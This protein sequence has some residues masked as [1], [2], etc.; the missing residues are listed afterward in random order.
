MKYKE[1]C[2]DFFA[3]SLF[4]LCVVLSFFASTQS[5]SQIGINTTAPDPSSM[6]DVVATDKGMLV[7]RVSLNNVANTMLD[8]TNT[9]ATGLLI[10]NTNA[11]VTGGSGVGFYYF[12]GS[13]W[14]RLATGTSA[15]DDHDFYEEGTTTPPNDINDDMFT[16]GNVAIG[17]TTADYALDIVED[18]ETR[19]INSLINSTASG[20]VLSYYNENN[21]TNASSTFGVYNRLIANS[22]GT[23]YGTYN[24]VLF[25]SGTQYGIFNNIGGTGTSTRYGAYNSAA[26]FGN[27]THYG[28]YNRAAGPDNATLYGA[29]QDVDSDGNGN[30]TGSHNRVQGNGSGIYYGTYNHVFSGTGDRYGSYN[31]VSSGGSGNHYGVY[32]TI[33]SAVGG[34][35][36][37]VYSDA[38]KAGSYAGYF[39]GTLSIGTNTSNNYLLPA[40]RGTANQI[41]QTDGSGNVSWV[42]ATSLGDDD[43]YAESTGAPPT[44][45]SDDIYTFGNV[46]IGKNTADYNLDVAETSDTRTINL[47]NSAS[48]G[49]VSGIFNIVNGTSTFSQRGTYNLVAGAGN[50]QQ[51][52]TYNFL[53]GGGS[54]KYGTYN[55]ISG[56]PSNN[57]YGNY[58]EITTAS[59][60]HHYGT[61]N[62]LSGDSGAFERIGTYNVMTADAEST[63]VRNFFVT[64]T[65]EPLFGMVNSINNSSSGQ[66]FGIRNLLG[67]NGSTGSQFG[68]SNEF[69]GT[70]NAPQTGIFNSITNDGSGQKIGVSNNIVGDGDDN[71]TGMS[72]TLGGSGN[73]AHRGVSN[74][75]I[76][77]GNGIHYGMFNTLSGT[78]TGSKY[79]LYT[80]IQTGAGGTH[81]GVYSEVL[82]SGSYAGYFL[83]DV[84]IGTN[85]VNLYTLPASRG[86]ANQIMETDG[87]G[88]LSWI[89]T[90]VSYWSRTGAELDVAT[91]GDD[92]HFTSDQTTI[93]FA[94]ST[95]TPAPL[96]HMFDGGSGNADRM[97]F[98]HSPAFSTW[99]LEY[100]DATDSFIFRAAGTERVEIDLNNNFPLR[101]YGTARAED[102]ESD[103]T[104]YPDYVF[105][106]YFKGSS[107]INSEYSFQSLDKVEAFIKEKGHLPG[108]KSYN[109]VAANDMTINLAE[110]SVTNLEKIEE[111]FLYTIELKKENEQLK[112]KQKQ[113]EERLK[114]IE[115]QLEKY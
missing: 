109:E 114:A 72:T 75:L 50:N 84:A 62:A 76:G 53:N 27:G 100:E 51:F 34:T 77:T 93:T 90:P 115:K 45:I 11:A 12:T 7:P 44:N 57:L 36:Y 26:G 18:T 48:S 98:A 94:Q 107:E 39:L 43:F 30:H 67:V 85:G 101:V 10:Y 17:K 16:Q 58:N 105:E 103:T 28:A 31:L 69:Q 49:I 104:T 92:I 25:G 29:Y 8:G 65:T 42:D 64:T 47:S 96:I 108:V 21:S 38:V 88:N 91:V 59:G 63:G 24:E 112:Q 41:M 97:L 82:K 110:T 23:K 52:G 68:V 19:A 74:N 46:A 80:L 106:S 111:L 87:A 32:A 9:A 37:G 60:R 5:F 35:H 13:V 73:G 40:S 4:L 78:G 70:T 2:T 99:G 86:T 89:N 1:C 95:G 55:S 71:H 22:S 15:S 61:Y 6:L 14:Q 81:F 83:G 102:F 20:N 33:S 79:G 56:T 54:T 113:L 3:S 66:Q